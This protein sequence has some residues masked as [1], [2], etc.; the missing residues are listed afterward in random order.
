MLSLWKYPFNYPVNPLGSEMGL[1][2]CFRFTFAP[3]LQSYL[4][5]RPGE[6]HSR[7]DP[8]HHGQEA[9]HPQHVGHCPRR[10]RKV[11]PDRLPRC[12]SRNYRLC[13]G[14][15]DENHR[16]QEGRTGA[17]HHHQG[18]VSN[19]SIKFYIIFGSTFTFLG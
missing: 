15:R 3:S 16:Y 6:L 10:P 4:C 14:R 2:S 1:N 8:Y 17:V 13:Q 9:Q 7:R 5:P 19:F 12:E 18:D 11:D